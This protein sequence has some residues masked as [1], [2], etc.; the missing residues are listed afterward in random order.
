[1]DE[2]SIVSESLDTSEYAEI[3]ILPAKPSDL[4]I[5]NKM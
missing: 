1:M 2:N 5:F 4:D 3:F